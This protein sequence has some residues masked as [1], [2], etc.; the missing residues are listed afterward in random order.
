[1]GR[2]FLYR[3]HPLSVGELVGR[4]YDPCIVSAPGVISNGLIEARE[5][6]HEHGMEI[7][8]EGVGISMF[9]IYRQGIVSRFV[10]CLK[11]YE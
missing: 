10:V 4:P 1:M 7:G 3:M 8:E 9:I 2:Y 11:V 6:E 5:P